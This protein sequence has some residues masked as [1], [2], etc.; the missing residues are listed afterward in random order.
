[1]I[2]AIPLLGVSTG[3]EMIASRKRSGGIPV[4]VAEAR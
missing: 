4:V 3:R 1:M 2:I